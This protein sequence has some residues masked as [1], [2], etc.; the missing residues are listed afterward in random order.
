[1]FLLLWYKYFC[2]LGLV[3]VDGG[4]SVSELDIVGVALG[5][6]AE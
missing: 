1:M 6:R 3:V 2:N 4:D 5:S